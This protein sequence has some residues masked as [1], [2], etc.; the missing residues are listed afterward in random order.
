MKNKN[1]KITR[2]FLIGLIIISINLVL[3]SNSSA[4]ED[5]DELGCHPGGY[6]ISADVS[7]IQAEPL[8]SYTLEVEGTGE[9]VVIDVFEGAMDNDVFTISPS[10]IIEDNSK[11]DL[12]S[13]TDSVRVELEIE[14][15][16]KPGVYTLRILSRGPDLKGKNSPLKELDIEVTVGRK[17]PLEQLFDHN[18]YY[19]AGLGLLFMLPGLAIFQISVSR[20]NESKKSTQKRDPSER[21]TSPI[22]DN[23]DI[24]E[25]PK[26]DIHRPTS[27]IEMKQR[28]YQIQAIKENSSNI[29]GSLSLVMENPGLISRE[30][31]M[32][33]FENKIKRNM[34]K[35][36]PKTFGIFLAVGLLLLIINVFLIVGTA[37]DLI[38]AME[39]ET[40]ESRELLDVENFQDLG[41]LIHIILGSIGL[42][43]GIIVV[44]GTFSNVPRD[45]LKLPV[46]IMALALTF[47]FL[48]GIFIFT[49]ILGYLG[50]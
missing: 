20:K 41:L 26:K 25:D 40:L 2:L 32:Q 28:T 38:F 14:M 19:L 34:I 43:M 6:E 21:F 10:N 30:R 37:L 27:H 31:E 36:E 50:G 33:L 44:F 12:D 8:S 35:D 5:T 4:T 9:D 16:E 15:P 29:E 17:S 3:V 13:D 49:E 47:N 1:N 23:L 46:Y 11:Y 22:K 39:M 24:K 42:F 45:K 7:E 18:N 48:Y